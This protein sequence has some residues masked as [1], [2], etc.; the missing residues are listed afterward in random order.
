MSYK[1]VLFD[2]DGTLLNTLKDIADSV[3][4]VLARAGYRQYDIE[5]YRYFV[6]DGSFELARRVLPESRRNDKTIS[7]TVAAIDVEYAKRWADNTVP[8]KGI[9][10][11][12][13]EI[14]RLGLRKCIL[15]NKAQSF[16]EQS[17]EILLS[18]WLFDIVQGA[19]P[20]IPLKP[21]PTAAKQ[22]AKR[23]NILPAEFLYLG[24][25]ATDMKTAAAAGMYPVGAVWGFRTPKELS[26]AGAKALAE[27]PGDVLRLLKRE[28]Q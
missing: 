1:A 28:I 27:T 23:L 10:E 2:L 7:E 20:G 25:T 15:S 12:L 8:Y 22:I 5:A 21:D 3:N 16:T 6:G 9:P 13:D 11:M 4:A 24:D 18:R 17:V 19:Q 14:T 26:D